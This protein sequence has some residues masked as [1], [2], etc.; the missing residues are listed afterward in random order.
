MIRP[1]PVLQVYVAEKTAANL[2]IAA[3]RHPRPKPR[4]SH[5]GKSATTFFN[6]RLAP[7]WANKVG[8]YRSLYPIPGCWCTLV[9]WES[10]R[11]CG[12]TT[13]AATPII[14]AG[15]GRPVRQ[16]LDKTK[17]RKGRCP[18]LQFADSLRWQRCSP[19]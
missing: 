19:A 5:S 8:E 14:S 17:D 16:L 13:R 6:S 15:A 4:E 12:P 1:N 2:V 11:G 9:R 10:N 7:A 3:H 18:K